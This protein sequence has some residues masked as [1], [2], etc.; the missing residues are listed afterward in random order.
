M[1]IFLLKQKYIA[2]YNMNAELTNHRKYFG[3]LNTLML[4]SLGVLCVV[5]MKKHMI[6]Y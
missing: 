4:P 6:T 3:K 5:Y 2:T 1:T